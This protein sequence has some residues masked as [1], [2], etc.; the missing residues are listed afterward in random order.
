MTR[1]GKGLAACRQAAFERE[2]RADRR[3]ATY[4]DREL[5]LEWVA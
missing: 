1:K 4:S 3:K 5:L 2:R